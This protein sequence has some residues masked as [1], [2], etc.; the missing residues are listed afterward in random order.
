MYYYFE[1]DYSRADT[2]DWGLEIQ[3]IVLTEGQKA[4]GVV[5]ALIFQFLLWFPIYLFLSGAEFTKFGS[6]AILFCGFFVT[7]NIF[8]A[9]VDPILVRVFHGKA[10]HLEP[11]KF[12]S[13]AAVTDK[14]IE[15][16]SRGQDIQYKWEAFHSV[17]DTEKNIIF[18]GDTLHAVIPAKCFSHFLE[19]D[20]FVR[21][22]KKRMPAYLSEGPEAFD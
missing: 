5:M 8:T 14:G 15:F 10:K 11:K 22:C 16:K 12:S 21:E 4:T 1:Y 20:A 17:H 19:K 7:S 2:L 9:F 6:A 13:E 3:N 18:I